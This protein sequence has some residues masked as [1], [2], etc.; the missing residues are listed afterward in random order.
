MSTI[1]KGT[2]SKGI[3]SLGT[4]S[5]SSLFSVGDVPGITITSGAPSAINEN[6]GDGQNV[7][8]VTARDKNG[9]TSGFAFAI[10][11]TDEGSFSINSSSG[12]VTLT[13]NPNFEAKGR[14]EFTV[15]ATKSGLPKGSKAIV[16]NINNLDDTAPT[17]TSGATATAIAEN[18]GAGQV[19]Y[20]VTADDS[21]D[22][23]GGVTFALS[24]TQSDSSL[25][26]INST[27][28]AVTLTANPD[29]ET[30]SSY[31]FAVVATDAA[32]NSTTPFNVTL[33]ITNVVDVVPSFTASTITRDAIF[34]NTGNNITLYSI[35]SNLVDPDNAVTSLDIV[36]VSPSVSSGFFAIDGS[37]NLTTGTAV[38]DHESAT[39]HAVT[40]N[41]SYTVGG[42]DG[43]VS[44]VVNVPISDR[45]ITFSGSA[46]TPTIAENSGAGQLIYQP[47]PS[48]YDP[49][50]DTSDLTYVLSGADASHFTV[51]QHTG[52]NQSL[53]GAVYL[54]ADPDYETKSSYAVTL[55]ANGPGSPPADTYSVNLTLT[56]TDVAEST[57]LRTFDLNSDLVSI[58]GTNHEGCSNDFYHF[59]QLGTNN[60]FIDG[61]NLINSTNNALD[62][63]ASNRHTSHSSCT[64][65]EIR[66]QG[67]SSLQLQVS[68]ATQGSQGAL[69]EADFIWNKINVKNDGSSTINNTINKSDCSFSTG[70]GSTHRHYFRISNDVRRFN[71]TTGGT[72]TYT[73]YDIEFTD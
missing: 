22:V 53:D 5:K 10:T 51:T 59:G 54:T 63:I 6:S 38:F 4:I 48:V 52:S 33:A 49:Q 56:I 26:S 50:Y 71:D 2:A 16:L 34:E 1:R 27:T 64:F 3:A 24:N 25:F 11:G 58:F 8:T 39:S 60:V 29:F 72:D 57:V 20:T 32:G 68:F 13:G 30:K 41:A 66:H 62:C 12:V 19:I 61:N 14:Y 40:I 31:T 15:E 37:N 17:I 43:G 47:F 7:Y 18:S 36:D 28:G 44:F 73:G 45:G 35:G 65:T 42:V 46:V 55:T 23:S 70:L 9:S 21:S 69:A 67:N